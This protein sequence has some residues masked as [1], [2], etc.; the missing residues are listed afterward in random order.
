MLRGS[1][2]LAHSEIPFFHCLIFTYRI[3]LVLVLKLKGTDTVGMPL[4]SRTF[5]DFGQ[6]P[7]FQHT[8]ISTRDS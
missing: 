7:H 4:Q 8:I 1:H 5:L 6:I 3:Q 2:V